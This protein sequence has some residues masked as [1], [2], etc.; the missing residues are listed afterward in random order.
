[1]CVCV[2]DCVSFRHLTKDAL[3]SGM[4]VISH[5]ER[6]LGKLSP[7]NETIM[8]C[9][10]Q[11]PIIRIQTNMGMSN[12]QANPTLTVRYTGE[13]RTDRQMYRPTP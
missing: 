3:T 11:R 9:G 5:S 13:S 2:S 7:I 1:M 8:A 12:V 6:E 4:N 10:F